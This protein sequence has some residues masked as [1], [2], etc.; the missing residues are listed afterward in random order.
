M[1]LIVTDA[2]VLAQI[3]LNQAEALALDAQVTAL[4]A[5][6]PAPTLA[7]WQTDRA[8][9]A[10]W[11]AAA[12]ARL[13]G[14][15][16]FGEWNGVVAD[17]NSAVAWKQKLDGYQAILTAVANGTTPTV[18][19][20]P[21]PTVGGVSDANT[22]QMVTGATNAIGSVASSGEGSLKWIAIGLVAIAAVAVFRK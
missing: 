19:V 21:T 11:A 15:F 17:G 12:T 6:V 13:S 5:K 2:D 8:A 18:L 14:G 10:A 7:A 4:G 16:I 22:G 3:A 1:P 9:W 20:P